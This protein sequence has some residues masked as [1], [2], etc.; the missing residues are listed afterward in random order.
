MRDSNKSSQ[1]L[2]S[3]YVGGGGGGGGGVTRKVLM[4]GATAT[5]Y[6]VL[7]LV[8]HYVCCWLNCTVQH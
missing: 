6:G 2:Q 7:K 8:F 3:R 1:S 5:V 4:W